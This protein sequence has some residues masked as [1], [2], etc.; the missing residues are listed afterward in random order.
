MCVCVAGW[1]CCVEEGTCWCVWRGDICVCV[2]VYVC[3]EEGRCV[4]VC[5]C[6]W[7]AGW[8]CVCVGVF[9]GGSVCVEEGTCRCVWRGDRYVCVEEG[10]CVCVYVC[11]CVCEGWG[12]IEANIQAPQT[13]T[14][15]QS[16]SYTD[17]PG[18]SCTCYAHEPLIHMYLYMYCTRVLINRYSH[19]PNMMRH[20]SPAG[21]RHS[22]N[23]DD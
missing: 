2:Y 13:A 16:A 21:T 18:S 5:V 11:V 17:R 7:V 8:E 9:V 1:E 12:V 6:G 4:C 3:V 22:H 23:T 14:C 19:S 15:M 20:S 10:R